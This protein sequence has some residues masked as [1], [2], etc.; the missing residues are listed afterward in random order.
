M[1]V[2]IAVSSAT[3]QK[4]PAP[5]KHILVGESTPDQIAPLIASVFFERTATIKLTANR[6]R[7]LPYRAASRVIEIHAGAVNSVLESPNRH[8]AHIEYVAIVPRHIIAKLAID[9]DKLPP[10]AASPATAARNVCSFH[11]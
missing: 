2:F 6:R 3:R 10:C 4:L 7:V 5:V 1:A 8:A 9:D 11:H